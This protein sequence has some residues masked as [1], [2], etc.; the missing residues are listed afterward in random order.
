[1]NLI[2]K[3]KDKIKRHHE[4][5]T[6]L[7]Y[8]FILSDGIAFVNQRDWDKIANDNTVFLS[9]N[10][11][12]AIESNSPDNTSQRYAMAYN[13]E[14]KPVVIVS[15]QVAEISGE[16]LMPQ[17]KDDTIKV[18]VARSYQERVLVCGNLVSSGLHGVGF[19]SDLDA[20]M[21]WK[22]VAEILYRVRQSEKLAGKIDFVMIKDIKG[23]KLAASEILERF[24][25]RRIQTD[26][27]MVL[28]LGDEVTTF[29]DY[30][31][32]LT[33][34]YRNRLKKI[35]KTLDKA[36]IICEK[37]HLDEM[38]DK[39]LHQLYLAVETK[40]ATRLATLPLGYFLA[41]QNQLGNNF[42]C[43]GIKQDNELLGF[44]TTIKDKKEA[45]GY[46]VG[47]DY[48]ANSQYPI[49]FRLLQLV[50][51]SAIDMNC[52]RVLFGRTALGPKANLGAKPIDTFVWARHRVPLVNFIVRKLFRNMPFDT[53]PQRSATQ[54]LDK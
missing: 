27:D 37:L 41:L 22:I 50:V 39:K 48:Q 13:E 31:A 17:S 44:V 34:K 43:Y 15:C 54:K 45:V 19:A 20:G 18:K 10:Y 42:S 14:G 8:K 12:Q 6:K 36:E 52:N 2:N 40:S 25:Y 21:G 35:I 38:M 4:R 3:A 29:D 28:D 11:L 16:N 33:G 9:R 30:L 47:I 23:N 5:H 24:S 32:I 7:G 49:Y 1:M 51:Q 26:P 46:Y 53:A